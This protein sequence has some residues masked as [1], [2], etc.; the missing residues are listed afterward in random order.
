MT[1]LC[2]PWRKHRCFTWFLNVVHDKQLNTNT[3]SSHTHTHTLHKCY[4]DSIQYRQ[5]SVTEQAL[6]ERGGEG[7]EGGVTIGCL[8]I[9]REE[10]VRKAKDG[11]RRQCYIL[12]LPFPQRML[13]L[14]PHTPTLSLSRC[15]IIEGR[16]QMIPVEGGRRG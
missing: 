13:T 12:P 14:T 7:G 6:R 4:K 11:S 9:E 15:L 1:G 16:L 10:A 3:L 2:V 8:L 5:L